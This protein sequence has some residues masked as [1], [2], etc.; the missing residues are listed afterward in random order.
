MVITKEYTS[1]RSR[2]GEIDSGEARSRTGMLLLSPD[3]DVVVGN[4][5]PCEPHDPRSI[6]DVG[7]RSAGST[8]RDPAFPVGDRRKGDPVLF[9]EFPVRF[10]TVVAY[11]PGP[12]VHAESRNAAAGTRTRM[13]RR[14]RAAYRISLPP[15]SWIFY[16]LDPGRDG[17]IQ[18]AE[19][20]SPKGRT[21]SRCP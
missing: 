6:D 2:I 1:G 4:A 10:R 12:G 15:G 19:F 14:A 16:S 18:T 13:P 8:A 5:V 20:N 9:G 3:Q 21:G 17:G 11:G 7:D